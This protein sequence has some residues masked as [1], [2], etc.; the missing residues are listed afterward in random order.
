[1]LSASPLNAQRALLFKDLIKHCL[2]LYDATLA[3]LQYDFSV[4]AEGFEVKLSGFTDKLPVLMKECLKALT[5][6]KFKTN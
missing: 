3:G 2:I 4:L 6:M 1:M 5:L